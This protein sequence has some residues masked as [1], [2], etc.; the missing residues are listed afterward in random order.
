MHLYNVQ[1]RGVF[2]SMAEYENNAYFWQKVDSLFLSSG[3]R[4]TR[5]KGDVHPVFKNLI[6]PLEYGH[7]NDTKS[8]SGEGVSV[9]AGSLDRNH[10]TALAVAADILSKELDVKVLVGCT[11][12]EVEEVLRFLNQTDFQKTVLIRRGYKIPS[13]SFTN[14]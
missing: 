7:I 11:E 1:V 4:I 5:K 13:W 14:D 12:E 6:Y 9:Y 8:V 10:I 2:L 3:F